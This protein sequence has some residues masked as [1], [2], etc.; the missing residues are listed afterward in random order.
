M[1][2]QTII[3]GWSIKKGDYKVDTEYDAQYVKDRK[4]KKLF[5][6]GMLI[7]SGAAALT[8]LVLASSLA[9]KI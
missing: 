5:I 9:G 6:K 4:F 7:L 8:V 1:S 3:S 2:E